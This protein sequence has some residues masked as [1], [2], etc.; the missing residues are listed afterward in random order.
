MAN[1]GEASVKIVGDVRDFARQ[2][3]ADLNRELKKIKLDPV[4][5]TLDTD[6]LRES[7]TE[8]GRLAGDGVTDGA[9]QQLARNR[10]RLMDAG[11]RAGGHLGE[12]MA[13]GA[14]DGIR[15]NQDSINRAGSDSGRESGDAA[16]RSF[17]Q[18]FGDRARSAFLSA[19]K[20]AAKGFANALGSALQGAGSAVIPIVSGLATLVGGTFVAALAVILGPALAGIVSGAIIALSGIGLGLGA[21]GLGAFALKE[22]EPLKNAF[23][24]LTKT[25]KDVGQAAAKPL[26]KPLV[27]EIGNIRELFRQLQPEFKSIFKSLA[28]ALKPLNQSLGIFIGSLVR[29]IKGSMPGILAALEG[30]GK[31]LEF[32]GGVLGDFFKTIFS[33]KDV[34]DNTTEALFKIIFG[35]LKLLGPLISGLNVIF[36]AWNNA[37]ILF[38]NSDIWSTILNGITTFVDGGTGAIQRIKDAWGPLADAIQNVWDKLKAFAAEDDP[39]KLEE[40]FIA[41]VDAVKEAWGPLGDFIGTVWNEALAFVQRLWEEK[42][43]PWWDETAKPWL[44]AAIQEAFNIAWEAAKSAVSNKIDQMIGRVQLGVATI[45]ARIRN[46]IV[47]VPTIF[48]NAF[49]R[50]NSAIATALASMAATAGTG[51]RTVIDRIRTGLAVAGATVRNAFNGAAGWLLAAGRSIIDGLVNGIRGAYGRVRDAVAGLGALIP[52]WA[53]GALGINSPAKVMIPIGASTMEGVEVGIKDRARSLRSV[54]EGMTGG[55]ADWAGSA[56]NSAKPGATS[57]SSFVIEAGA[58]VINGSGT[59]AGNAAA[60]AVLARL[61]QAG[62]VR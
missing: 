10:G 2:V 13:D 40:K 36:G 41:F 27:A 25:F 11:R 53:R 34:I 26:L 17:A 45:I 48:A 15:N 14:E 57:T 24:E 16:G 49:V 19:A 47:S 54:V 37:I 21:I 4:K 3:E 52:G 32:A 29:G 28:P 55:M 31:G 61:A 50:A 35:P 22:V 59:G 1:E 5:I 44:E 56:I 58:I 18:R 7:A 23:K 62:R 38:A 6:S 12:G 42:F 51:A 46:G 33:N 39:K 8:A 43:I 60:E 20:T 9:E 30:F